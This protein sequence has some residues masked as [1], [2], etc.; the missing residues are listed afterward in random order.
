MEEM[1]LPFKPELLQTMVCTGCV[2]GG[3]GDV[4]AQQN[5]VLLTNKEQLIPADLQVV[6]DVLGLLLPLMFYRS[7]ISN[8]LI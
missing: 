1:V 3:C 6:F 7:E 2:E 8:G 5:K 4:S